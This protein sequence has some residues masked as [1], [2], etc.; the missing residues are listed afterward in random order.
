MKNLEMDRIGK[1]E[2]LILKALCGEITEEESM[3]LEAWRHEDPEHEHLFEE[4][5]WAW[6][7]SQIIQKT[8]DHDLNEDLS[9]L[10][11][12][13]HSQE[14]R[15]YHSPLRKGNLLPQM[16]RIAAA[17]IVAFILSW[18][19]QSSW[20][21]TRE[22]EKFNKIVTSKG[23]RTR[24]LL[25][26]GTVIWLNAESTLEYPVNFTDKNRQVVLSGEAFFKVKKTSHHDPFVVKV[27]GLDIRVT[28]TS[29]NV[30]AYPNEDVIETTLVE[31]S[32]TLMRKVGDKWQSIRLKPDEKA[33][34]L[35]KGSGICLSE[36]R[37]DRPTLPK[38]KKLPRKEHKD[39]ERIIISPDV[40][41]ENHVAWKDNHLVFDNETFEE[42]AYE[43]ERW[44]DVKIIFQDPSLKRYRY[45]GKFINKESLEQI[46]RVIQ[47]TTP[48]QYE[49]EKNKVIIRK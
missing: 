3:E 30:K 31:G 36:V 16:L 43:L 37:P 34:L 25:A 10:E 35:K 47:M 7:T 20:R 22:S 39:K 49:I 28:G 4:M 2:N 5:E 18:L 26:D 11:G 27:P 33:T 45:T 42:I 1:Y 24:V 17:F 12:W 21:Y 23:Q 14:G 44:F 46:L 48:F 8:D 19:I 13:L 29:F 41:I 6:E 38:L 32:I 40:N 9:K 15:K